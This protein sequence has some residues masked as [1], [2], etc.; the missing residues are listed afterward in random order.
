MCSNNKPEKANCY[1][2]SDYTHVAKG[3]FLPRI[4][5]HDVRNHSKARKNE[6]IHLRVPEESEEMLVKNRVTT[7]SW[8]KE[9]GV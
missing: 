2:S 9:C 6:D 4:V 1:Y 5:G 3:F 7:S 8:V